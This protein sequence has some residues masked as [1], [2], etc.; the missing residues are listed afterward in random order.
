VSLISNY[1]HEEIFFVGSMVKGL[2]RICDEYGHGSE[3]EAGGVLQLA[4]VHLDHLSKMRESSCCVLM[5]TTE[6][7]VSRH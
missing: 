6:H 4:Y 1:L 5:V 3:Y 2:E 7:T